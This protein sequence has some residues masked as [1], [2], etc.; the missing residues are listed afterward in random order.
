MGTFRFEKDSLA[1]YI[2]YDLAL[3]RKMKPSLNYVIKTLE[4]LGH[5]L[6]INSLDKKFDLNKVV[7]KEGKNY[8]WSVFKYKNATLL[9]RR[10][11]QH[12]TIF[13]RVEE[14]HEY[15]QGLTNSIIGAFTFHANSEKI[16]ENKRDRFSDLRYEKPF[17][18]LNKHVTD[19]FRNLTEKD[20]NIHWVWNS[21]SWKREDHIDIEL[22]FAAY[23]HISSYDGTIF[24]FEELS[25][26]HLTLFAETTMLK[27][28]EKFK[29]KIGKSFNSEYNIKSVSTDVEDDYYHNV[30]IMLVEKKNKKKTKWEDVYSLTRWFYKEVFGN[31]DEAE[32]W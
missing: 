11:G 26:I 3:F 31:D 28:I 32:E 12:L 2:K 25:S 9:V 14:P 29:S 5:S 7:E 4:E 19:L 20:A 8:H 17:I 18:D 10:Y 15:R 30:G 23:E 22:A 6:T 24:A 1:R 27:E 16:P 13:T 21:V